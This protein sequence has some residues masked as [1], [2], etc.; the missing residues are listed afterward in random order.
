M[1][2]SAVAVVGGGIS[3][4][5]AAH[6]LRTP[7][8]PGRRDHRA[9]AARP[10]SAACCAPSTWPGCPSTSA[11]RRSWPA[12]PRCPRCWPSS[13]WP[14]ERVHPTAA[15]RLGARGRCAP[16]PLPAG[17]LLGVPTSAARL[18]GLLSPDGLAAVA[19]EPR[20]PAGWRPGADVGARRAAARPV[21]RRA[22]RPAGRPAARRRLRR[23]GRRARVCAP[24][25]PRWPRRS[26]P[27]P[28]R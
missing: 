22:G 1:S 25:C 24:R 7:A 4:L 16:S 26:T 20:P 3:G 27:A 17:T 10:A 19:A 23:P 15:P 5:A 14:T 11:P 28:R 9:R 13:G 8:R 18:E 12:A 6:R 2:R 21:R